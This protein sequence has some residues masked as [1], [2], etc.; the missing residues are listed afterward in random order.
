MYYLLMIKSLFAL[1]SHPLLLSSWKCQYAEERV[2]IPA[3]VECFVP[4]RAGKWKPES[5]APA[6][7]IISSLAFIN[8]HI[9]RRR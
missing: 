3:S 4:N 2:E 8:N 9:N 6:H 5:S 1:R 7:I